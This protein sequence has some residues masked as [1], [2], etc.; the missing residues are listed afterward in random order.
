MKN[1]RLRS[2]LL[3]ICIAFIAQ[4]CKQEDKGTLYKLDKSA[5]S[6]KGIVVSSHP[7][8]SEIGLEILKKGGNAADAAIAVQLALA[9]VYPRAGNIG[10]G[11][12]LVHRDMNGKVLT[13]DYREKASYKAHKDMFL[14]SLGQLIPNLSREGI[15]AIGVPGT[16]A[17]LVETHKKVGKLQPWSALVEPA[18][19]LAKEG[20]KITALEAERLN[21]NREFFLKFN[22][23][24]MPF[25]SE[26]EWKEGD[27]LIQKDLAQTL[28]LIADYGKDGFYGQ[29]YSMPFLDAMKKNN[30]IIT[31]EDLDAYVAIWRKPYTIQWKGYEIHTMGLPSSGGIVLGQI[32]RMIENRLK[33]SLG[34]RDVQN[35]HLIVESERRAF[36]ERI[37]HL[38]DMEFYNVPLDSI[39]DDTYLE[40]LFSDFNPE[41]AS[42]S[43]LPDTTLQKLA[44]ESFETTHISIVD[45]EGNAASVTT[46]LNENYGSKIWVQGGGY[47]LNNEMDDFTA[48]PGVPNA[49]GLSGSEANAI[50]PGKRMIS[51][52][53][54]TIVESYGELYM[55]IGTNGGPTITTSVLQVLLNKLSFGMEIDQAA[56]EPRYHHQYLP[57]EIMYEKD[58]FS[59]E[60]IQQL[61][62]M[63]HHLREVE[64]L[65]YMK[66]IYRDEKGVSHGSGDPAT[67]DHVAVW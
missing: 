11:G 42:V 38:G 66:A 41:K 21:T 1:S 25:I 12:F 24:T 57:D 60:L 61:Q 10:G 18:I 13:L 55:V 53:T 59:P 32:I 51:S 31:Q 33:D 17:G 35:V 5:K 48:K 37:K 54:P 28:Q 14:D 63:G 46:T 44:K 16:V 56:Q 67:D 19:R 36:A 4:S 6:N 9:V 3:I 7:L 20:F 8:A 26:D 2:I 62:S 39:R 23:P 27:V 49:Y 34:Y 64:V 22:P 45:K 40:N 15:L 47:F 50:M 43:E 52:M 29:Q 65:G 30:G 58:A